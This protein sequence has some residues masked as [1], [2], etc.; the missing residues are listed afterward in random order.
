MAITTDQL[1][2]GAFYSAGKDGT[3]L[4][5]ITAIHGKEP[6]TMTIDWIGKS[7][8]IPKREWGPG[9]TLANPPSAKTFCEACESRLTP[10]EIE[11]LVLDFILTPEESRKVNTIGKQTS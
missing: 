2:V 9:A 8:R 6:G 10:E 4:R 7:I 5:Q 1:E 3:Q 11:Q